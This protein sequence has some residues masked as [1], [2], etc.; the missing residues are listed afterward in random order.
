[1]VARHETTP[2]TRSSVA[3]FVMLGAANTAATFVLF[4]ALQ[5][6]SSVAVA[7]SVAFAAGLCFSTALTARVVF[8]AKT[9]RSRRAVFASCYVVIYG[10]GLVVSHLLAKHVTAWT[11]SAGTIVVTAPLGYLCGRAVLVQQQRGIRRS[12]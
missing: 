5:H 11:V 7:Y 9:T 2:T 4:T 3:R 12:P 1:M 6:V 10:V 8:G